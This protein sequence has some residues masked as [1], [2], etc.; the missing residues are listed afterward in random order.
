MKLKWFGT[1]T[2]LIEYDGSR[3]LFDPFLPLSDK[4]YKPSISDFNGIENILVSHGHVDHIAGIPDIVMQNAGLS[5]VFCTAAPREVLISKGVG[6]QRV[7]VIK[8]GD[9]LNFG[10]FEVRVLKGKHIVFNKMLVLKKLFNPRILTHWNN[11]KYLIKENKVCAEAGETVVYDIKVSNKRI[12]LLGSLNLDKETDYPENADFLILPYQ[13]RDHIAKYAV[14]FIERLK[15]KKVLL[16]HYNDSFPPISSTV[17]TEPFVSLMRSVF[18]GIPVI[19]P[20][21]GP[22]WIEPFK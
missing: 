6:E 4:V 17:D 2:I 22:K 13:G 8:P 3:L 11:T 15:P 16:D 7:Q 1:A 14:S 9:I 19:C 18:P 12:L 21:A 20:V 10:V 5:T